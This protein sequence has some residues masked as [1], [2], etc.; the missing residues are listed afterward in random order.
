MTACAI[1]RLA[2]AGQPV[3][4]DAGNCRPVG[5][6]MSIA[7]NETRHRHPAG[8]SPGTGIA[9]PRLGSALDHESAPRRGLRARR[10]AARI[11]QARDG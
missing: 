8:K 9:R 6:A 10:Q 4:V 2:E 3:E 1:R 7:P 11:Q 5:T